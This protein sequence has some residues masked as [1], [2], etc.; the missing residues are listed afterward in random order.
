MYKTKIYI[1]TPL[2]RGC[3]LLGF[4]FILFL[5]LPS[6]TLNAQVSR[7]VPYDLVWGSNEGLFG[8]TGGRID[9]LW[10][11]GVQKIIQGGSDWIL[12]GNRG[13]FVS[14]DLLSW[15]ER[16]TALPR[17]LIKVYEDGQTRLEPEIQ[18][19]KNLAADPVNGDNL[20]VVFK[21]ALYLS[22]N[23][24]RSWQNLG[25]P[26]PRT[27]GLKGAALGYIEGELTVF[28]SHN[29]YG[30]FYITP[31]I[32]GARWTSLNGGLER[33]ET[34]TNP[35]E[36]SSIVMVPSGGGMEVYAAQS[37]R[38]RIYRLDWA[39]ETWI[40]LWSG[41]SGL[42]VV[43]S[44]HALEGSLQFVEDRGIFG[45]DI[46]GG[47]TN[48]AAIPQRDLENRIRSLPPGTQANTAILWDSQGRP[49][50]FSELWLL[51]EDPLG[52]LSPLAREAAGREGIY[53]PVNHAAD[54]GSLRPYLTLI[55]DRD[56][57]MVVID[58]KDDY[59][60]LRFVPQNPA[61]TEFGRVFNPID[62]EAFLSAM[63]DRGI[64]T[65]A[66]IVVFKDP[67]AA[68]RSNNAYAVWDGPGNRPWRGYY[69]V[70]FRSSEEAPERS[71]A[72]STA[73]LSTNDPDYHILRTWYDETW[74]DPYSELIWDYNVSVAE[75]LA[76][77]GFDEIQFDYIRFPTDGINLS[78]AQ[79]RWRDPGMD[80]DGAILSFLRHARG[81]INVPISIDIY[82][83]NGWYRTGAR[84]GQEVELLA[85]WVDVICPMYYPSHFEQGFLAQVP[86]ELRPQ[87]IY[88]QGTRRTWIIS[89]GTVTVRPWAQ[90]F[91]LNVSYDREF[92]GP[93]YVRRQLE[94]TRGA[95]NGGITY[96]NNLG[97]YD[98]VPRH[99]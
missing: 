14:H 42:G 38:R 77:R 98:E 50:I 25:N 68:L 83:A 34:T 43:E 73:I 24:G 54:P 44:L 2:S 96:W 84:T 99:E 72:L 97:R 53:L 61:L 66:R 95:G 1:A 17:K 92:Y 58:M 7:Q 94:G 23:G 86:P 31:N 89:R 82:G 76:R 10:S 35:D 8:R 37:F 3:L 93:E 12:F 48:P 27:S 11:G 78:D 18:Q 33:L 30:I 63:K 4:L 81:R 20:A 6:C 26:D 36:I 57:N 70:R 16:N 59:G 90:S 62:L 40:P 32:P 80:M 47:R 39:S 51:D 46:L 56:L 21:D 79:Y 67:E 52:R 87:R 65:V 64:Y 45:L 88:Y 22:R 5:L 19:I 9:T 91:F 75:E 28:C 69:D 41:G 55:D 85:P 60:R 15:E 74:V 49:S 29:L 71:P 13:V